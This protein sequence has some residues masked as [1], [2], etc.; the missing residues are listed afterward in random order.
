MIVGAI[1][2]ILNPFDLIPDWIAS[3]GFADDAVVLALAVRQ[4]QQ[5]LDD[6]MTWE[7]ASRVRPTP[8][9]LR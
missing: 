1:I 5:T 6:V 4:T 3:L 8:W 7:I 9:S 2:Y